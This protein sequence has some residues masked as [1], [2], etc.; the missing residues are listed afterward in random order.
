MS[1]VR[2]NDIPHLENTVLSSLVNLYLDQLDRGVN[3]YGVI[4]FL[5]AAFNLTMGRKIVN[6]TH[7]DARTKIVHDILDV[8]PTVRLN[9][10]LCA[11]DCSVSKGCHHE[12]LTWAKS[13]DVPIVHFPLDGDDVFV[14]ANWEDAAFCKL[15]WT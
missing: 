6:Q 3:E 4:K 7:S 14:F 11:E 5:K 9:M 15:K 1:K 2:L 12:V 13:N 8:V 10:H